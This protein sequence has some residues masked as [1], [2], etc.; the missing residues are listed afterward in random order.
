MNAY[1]MILLMSLI[2]YL[3]RMVPFA[4]FQR[5]IKSRFLYSLFS[6]MPYAVLSSMVFPSVFFAT[7]DVVSAS[8]A[9]VI[10]ITLAFFNVPM[11]IV[12]VVGSLVVFLMEA[13]F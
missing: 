2:T 4:F 1:L 6:Y 12:S 3:I 13:C 11:M 9:A 8:I 10:C 5:K 7:G